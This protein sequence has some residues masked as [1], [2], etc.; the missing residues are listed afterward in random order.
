MKDMAAMGG[1]GGMGAFYANM[2]TEIALTLNGN[3]Q[4]YPSIIADANA[5]VQKEK[6]QQSA[7]E[8]SDFLEEN[9]DHF[10]ISDSK[11]FLEKEKMCKWY[12]LLTEISVKKTK[13]N[14]I[15]PISMIKG[16]YFDK[17]NLVQEK[18]TVVVVVPEDRLKDLDLSIEKLP[19]KTATRKK[20][21]GSFEKEVDPF[22]GVSVLRKTLILHQSDFATIKTSELERYLSECDDFGFSFIEHPLEKNAKNI[23]IYNDVE[24]GQLM[25]TAGIIVDI[26]TR[27][28]VSGKNY[29]WL[30]IKSPRDVVRVTVW[31]NQMD[32]Y[33]KMLVKNNLILIKG[34]R[35]YGGIS[36]EEIKQITLKN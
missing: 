3:H 1:G 6:V 24:D 19:D 25:V 26:L 8:L 21:K 32:S 20:P 7:F 11:I 33:K 16:K 2:P 18:D 5:D 13:Q 15:V 4:M 17:F 9:K 12:Q 23:N 22:K 28:T 14:Y 34:L 29:Y 36:L 35:G 27:K 30:M 10:K 31:Q